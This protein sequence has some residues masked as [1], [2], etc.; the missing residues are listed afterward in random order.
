MSKLY[1]S[2]LLHRSEMNF[3]PEACDILFWLTV[4]QFYFWIEEWKADQNQEAKMQTW[5]APH[6]EQEQEK[7]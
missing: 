1:L 3:G 7:C 2:G 4:V 5:H 6:I